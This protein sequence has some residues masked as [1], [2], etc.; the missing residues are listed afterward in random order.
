MI[1][2]KLKYLERKPHQPYLVFMRFPILVELE[3]KDIGLCGESSRKTGVP[4]VLI[5][6]Y[7]ESQQQTQPT[8]GI[9]PEE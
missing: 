5:H 6:Q 7:D 1:I 9:G 2:I 3:F 8:N 4:A